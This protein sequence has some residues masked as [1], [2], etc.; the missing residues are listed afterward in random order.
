MLQK[1]CMLQVT[2]TLT[3]TMRTLALLKNKK[4]FC[5]V[6]DFIQLFLLLPTKSLHANHP[7]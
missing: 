7:V 3:Y 6:E 2:L 5:L 1:T 4:T